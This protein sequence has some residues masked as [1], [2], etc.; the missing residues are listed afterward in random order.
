MELQL[1]HNGSVYVVD[2]GNQRIQKF[3]SDGEFILEFGESDS[4]G[5]QF[6]SPLGIAIDNEENIYV[7]DPSKNKI[8]KLNSEGGNLQSY[9]P[10]F[11][12]YPMIPQGMVIDPYWKYLRCRYWS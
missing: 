1:V 7:S 3:T 9:G 4:Y 2:T 8:F 11:G 12:G 5:G 6:I 10:N